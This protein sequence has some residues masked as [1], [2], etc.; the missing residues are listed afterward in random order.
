MDTFKPTNP[1]QLHKSLSSAW[2]NFLGAQQCSREISALRR[3]LD[4]HIQVTN[5]SVTSLQ[6]ETTRQHELATAIA[7]SRSRI[8]QHTSDLK[9]MVTLRDSLSILQ[10]E[11][12]RDREHTLKKIIELSEKVVTQQESIE[13]MRSTMSQD[14]GNAQEQCR[15]AL[16]KV[17]FLQGELRELRA[18]NA[19]AEQRLA[20]LECQITTMASARQ[21]HLSGETTK[22]PNQMLSHREALTRLHGERDCEIPTQ[23]AA[24]ARK[25]LR[26]QTDIAVS[27]FYPRVKRND[28]GAP[29]CPTRRRQR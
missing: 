28:T 29:P 11:T 1:D 4:E 5:L 6:R 24:P 13:G 9:E 18:E 3:T 26:P 7:E 14:V 10:R 27:R 2:A 15:S 19:A 20:A 8:E 21:G 17:E 12:S 16:E 23:A 25:Y 22:F